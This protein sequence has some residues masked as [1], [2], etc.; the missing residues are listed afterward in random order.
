MSKQKIALP[1]GNTEAEETELH[2][3]TKKL[4]IVGLI[5]IFTFFGGLGSWMAITKLQGAII[6]KGEVIVEGYRKIVQHQEGGIVKKIY[7]REGDFVEKGQILI[8]LDGESILASRDLFRGQLYALLAQQARHEAEKNNSDSII[9]PE[10]LLS[11][12]DDPEVTDSMQSQEDIFY[13]R[14]DSVESK[15]TLYNEQIEQL[16]AKIESARKQ[17]VS[18]RKTIASLKEEILA[19]KDLVKGQYLDKPH[20][21]ELERTLNSYEVRE[22][23]L[24]SEILLDKKKISELE[25]QIDA[26]KKSYHL[27]AVNNIGQVHQRILE[28]KDKLRPVEDAYR[29]LDITAP[30]SGVVINLNVRTEGGVIGGGQALMEIVPQDDNL[31]VSAQV[32]TDKI[33]EVHKGGTASVSLAAFP[34]R[35]T[36]KVDGVVT[37]VSA[38]LV[39]P[40]NPRMPAHYLAYIELDRDSL[41]NAIKDPSL[42]TPG[43]P[44]QVFIQTEATTILSYL[45][46]PIT[47][48]MDQ[49]FR[50]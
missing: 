49:A 37:Y 38:D 43:M 33:D 10:T 24:E 21:M 42:L 44:A 11:N 46:T 30:V 17:I 36:P 3:S 5:L 8:R 26:F 13:S 45:I 31:I 50:E 23:Q 6:A 22:L 39:K 34:T 19:K 29:R 9:W 1:A 14:R 16:K 18:V 48:S 28:L 4:I 47:E 32:P 40:D 25:I 20:I 7:V 2:T 15:L 27:E 12:M 35:Y 41:I